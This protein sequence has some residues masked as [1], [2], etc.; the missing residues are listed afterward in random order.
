MAALLWCALVALTASLLQQGNGDGP[1]ATAPR[2]IRAVFSEQIQKWENGTI[3]YTFDSSV[4]IRIRN[5]IRDAMDEWEDYTCVIFKAERNERPN[6]V[7]FYS[8]PNEEYCTCDS[9]GD[10]G[11]KQLIKLGY[12]CQEKGEI[13]HLLGHILGFWHEQ[14]RPD[15]DV[16]VQ[17]N[18]A[19]IAKGQEANFDKL[20]Y[21]SSIDTVDQ[22]IGYDYSSIMHL[23][24]TAFSIN[25]TD[26]TEVTNE[27][28]YDHQ[29]RP[30]VGQHIK[31]SEKDI[32]NTNIYYGCPSDNNN[33]T[34]ILQV[35]VMNAKSLPE[36]TD[37]TVLLTVMK[38][39]GD[40]KIFQHFFRV[41]MLEILYG[42]C[43]L[44]YQ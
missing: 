40:N 9:L 13:L 7:E 37:P 22:I 26:T 8:R 31:I 21:N 1:A 39:N 4:S 18:F 33:M 2:V 42:M 30:K 41:T 35:N 24:P 43:I 25:G 34:G 17:I 10:R 11:G 38:S 23:K 32:Q 44:E 6:F 12:S 16:F 20:P 36:S 14:A 19:N 27:I 3:Y 15:R 29:G 5:I 28:E